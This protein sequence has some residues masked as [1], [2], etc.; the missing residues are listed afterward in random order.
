MT[1]PP[2]VEEIL[3]WGYDEEIR[4]AEKDQDHILHS[5]QYVPVL[6]KLVNDPNCP[7]DYFAFS[8]LCDFTREMFLNRNEKEIRDLK[9]VRDRIVGGDNSEYV[10]KWADYVERLYEYFYTLKPVGKEKARR[11]AQDLLVGPSRVAGKLSGPRLYNDVWEFKL[12]GQVNEY[13]YINREDGS[14]T[15]SQFYPRNSRFKRL[16]RWFRVP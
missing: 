15:Y 10:M 6:I 8:I 3:R 14:W 7:K 11:M 9:K 4:L 5:M 16:F 13:L 12:G 1:G 2:S